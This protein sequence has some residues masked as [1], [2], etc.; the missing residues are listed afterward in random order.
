VEQVAAAVVEVRQ[1]SNLLEQVV[2]E[3]LRLVD[4]QDAGS[5]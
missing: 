3:V 5:P 1:Q 4:D 2:R